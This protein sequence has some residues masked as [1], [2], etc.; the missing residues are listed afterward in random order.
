MA[1][2]CRPDGCI[3]AELGNP[4]IKSSTRG[5]ASAAAMHAGASLG[6]LS[7]HPVDSSSCTTSAISRCSSITGNYAPT[8]L[9]NSLTSS[10]QGAFPFRA[11]ASP[12]G[13]ISAGVRD[14]SASRSS[15]FPRSW[16]LPRGSCSAIDLAPCHVVPSTSPKP[17]VVY[18]TALATARS[19]DLSTYAGPS[20]DLAV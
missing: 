7:G 13:C 19:S 20:R 11:R 2:T 4:R 8:A 5:L 10:L 12:S 9:L 1:T 3:G 6:S 14:P 15:C 16:A 17:S 18:R